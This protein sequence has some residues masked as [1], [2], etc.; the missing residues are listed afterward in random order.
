MFLVDTR[1]ANRPDLVTRRVAHE[2]AHQWWGYQLVPQ[3]RGGATTLTESLAK[4]TEL[5]MLERLRGRDQVRELLDIELDRYLAG[6]SREE[7]RER[8][9]ANAGDE[10]YLYYS[11]GALVFQAVRD[12]IGEDAL[13]AALRKLLDE[14]REAATTLDL[15]RQLRNVS[16]P[17]QFA[18]I[19]EWFEKIVLYELAVDTVDVKPLPGGSFR[20]GAHVSAAKR[21]AAET[22]APTRKLPP[23]SGFTSTVS[24][25]S[26]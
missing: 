8:T 10:P 15:L 3:S 19:D 26:S 1:V 22:C 2:V 20:V 25:A 7:Q 21:E 16:T 5:M 6:R 17:A 9:L 11:K 24:T 12:L 18:I 13:N 4:Y 14:N 23:G